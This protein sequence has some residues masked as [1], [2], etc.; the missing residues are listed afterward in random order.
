MVDCPARGLKLFDG[1]LD[2]EPIG[3]DTGDAGRYIHHAAGGV[4]RD[5]NDR[6][7]V[8]IVTV[9]MKAFEIRG[10]FVSSNDVICWGIAQRVS[11]AE[12]IA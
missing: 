6:S 4:A 9:I 3:H 5:E 2:K 8:C 11:E 7:A 1:Q 12:G 10:P